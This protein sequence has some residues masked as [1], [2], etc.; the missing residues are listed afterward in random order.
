MAGEHRPRHRP[1]HPGRKLKTYEIAAV[2]DG[3]W[4]GQLALGPVPADAGAPQAIAAWGASFVLGLTTPQEAAAAGWPELGRHLADAGLIW[5]NAPIDDFTAPTARFE[6]RW[7]IIR[8]R[9]LAHLED[10]ERVLVHCHGGRGRSG[11]IVASLLVT[12]GLTPDAAIAAVRRVRPGAI[13][14]PDQEAWV[15]ATAGTSTTD[16]A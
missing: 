6:E 1:L 7:P 13:E 12:G 11:T 3:P 15:R 5:L 2:T 14:T 10:G 16:R 4:P 8:Q 9:L